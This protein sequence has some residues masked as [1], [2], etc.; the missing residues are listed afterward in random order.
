MTSL[1]PRR[2]LAWHHHCLLHL[3]VLLN[4]HK[5]CQSVVT[6]SSRITEVEMIL[7]KSLRVQ[8]IPAP[9]L[10]STTSPSHA[11]VTPTT[12]RHVPAHV[13][14]LHLLFRWEPRILHLLD[15][16]L[17]LLLSAHRHPLRRP[18]FDN[19]FCLHLGSQL[20]D[21]CR[22]TF[23]ISATVAFQWL[24]PEPLCKLVPV[25]LLLFAQSLRTTST[26]VLWHVRELHSRLPCKTRRPSLFYKLSLDHE[27]PPFF[28]QKL[29]SSS[30]RCRCSSRHLPQRA[31]LLF[32]LSTNLRTAS[33]GFFTSVPWN[34]SPFGSL[35]SPELHLKRISF[36]TVVLH[37]YTV[38]RLQEDLAVAR[39]RRDTTRPLPRRRECHPH[40]SSSTLTSGRRGSRSPPGYTAPHSA[41]CLSYSSC[42]TFSISVACYPTPPR[43]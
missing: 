30:T 36:L 24:P 21:R 12:E 8:V 29:S 1:A 18:N 15:L 16:P 3:G 31:R 19:F 43:F 17:H 38:G 41:S 4:R 11:G 7:R 39:L 5:H 22:L 2:P 23:S 32:L 6:L 34:S 28:P 9:V 40:P 33:R 14:L 26:T 42:P 37:V 27:R 25:V 10:S 13:M 20:R 35:P